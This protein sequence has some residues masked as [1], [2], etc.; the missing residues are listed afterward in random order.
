MSLGYLNQQ[1]T[2]ISTYEKRYSLRA[3]TAFNLNNHIRVGENAYMFFKNNPQLQNQNEGNLISYAYREPPIIPVY[4][5]AGNYAGSRS[6]GLSNSQNGYANAMRNVANNKLRGNNN[7]WQMTGNVFAE[8]DFLKHFTLRTQFGGTVDN[9]YNRYF[10]FTAYENAEG[11]TNANAYTELAGYNSSYTWTNTLKYSQDF[12]KHNL[13]LLLGNESISNYGRQV[14]GSNGN[15]VVSV[16]PSY[17]DLDTGNPAGYQNTNNN[18]IYSNSILSYFGRLDYSYA[19][20]YL[21]SATLR[22]DGSSFFANGR[23]YGTF[24]SV[25]LG[26]RLSQESF[27]KSLTWLNDL[28]LRAGYGTLGSLSGVNTQPNN[29]FNLYGST[30]GNSF[31]DINGTGSSSVLGTYA[32]QLGNTRTSWETDKELNLGIDATLLNH[33][34]F[35]LEYYKKTVTG[36]LFKPQLLAHETFASAPYVNAGN[37][38]NTGIDFSANYHGNINEFRFNVGINLSHYNNL[39]KS[40]DA[41]IPYLDENSDGSTRIANFSRL[42]PGQPLGEFYGYQVLGLYKDAADVASGAQYSGAKPG[43]FKLKDVNGDKKI[44][45]NDRTF[46]GNP[47]PKLTGGLNLSAGYKNFDLTAFLYG[48]YG[49]KV[50]NYTKYW[51]DFPQVFDGNVSADILAKSWHAGADNSHATIPV[52]SRQASLG[53]T[54]AF[55]SFYLENGSFLRLKSLQVGYTMPASMLKNSGISKVRIYVL[56]NNLFTITKYSG[57][58]PELQNSALYNSSRGDNTSFGIDFGNYPADEK[59]YSLGLQVTF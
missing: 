52:L 40:L 5:I 22:R 43:F 39:V 24:P 34:D 44:D 53:N 1:G 9:F 17:V 15:Y 12:G 8:A 28:K 31:Y 27:M 49:N 47:N 54:A 32:S 58:D 23:K 48:V 4:D 57:L 11:N 26:W 36:L 14:Q 59:R 18:G 20:K 45:A 30:G 35:S 51:T 37:I 13:K 38:Q 19:D 21:L 3:N 10:G 7:D 42:Q 29:A 41:S 46:I 2:L 25:T 16:D 56:V 33:I 50:A 55:N 6:P